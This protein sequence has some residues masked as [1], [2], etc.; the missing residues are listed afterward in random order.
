LISHL[1]S[2]CADLRFIAARSFGAIG[3][4]VCDALPTL[5]HMIEYEADDEV[6]WAVV[7]A[8]SAA[9]TEALPALIELLQRA[10]LRATP[11]IQAALLGIGETAAGELAR[12]L[13]TAD[14]IVVRQAA[15][16]VLASLGPKAEPAVPVLAELLDSPDKEIV[17]DAIVALANIGRVGRVCT[18][19]L[20]GFLRDPDETISEWATKALLSIGPEAVPILQE[21]RSNLD[22]GQRG[23]I[24]HV[25]E[26]LGAV[27]S[28]AISDDGFKGIKNQN[29]LELFAVVGALLLKHGPA[30]YD[31]LKQWIVDMK[32]KGE[33]R[34]NLPASSRQRAG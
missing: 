28:D 13:L 8:I 22:E 7:A 4:Q 30:S 9:G 17:L 1:Q 14:S 27:V 10:R 20:A 19:S 24:D 16:W 2:D 6:C 34:T 31:D 21:L 15:A 26:S 3:S 29:A 12:T 25:L 33:V 23:S 5:M 32:A 18:A 11:L